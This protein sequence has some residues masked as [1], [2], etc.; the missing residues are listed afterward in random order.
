MYIIAKKLK[1]KKASAGDSINNEIIKIAV[2]VIAPHF[3]KLFNSI[4]LDGVS[5]SHGQRVIL[6]LFI[7]Q[8]VAQILEITGVFVLA[9]A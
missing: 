8:G 7:K 1:G 2:D 9:V 5:P 4:L 6:C 3:V